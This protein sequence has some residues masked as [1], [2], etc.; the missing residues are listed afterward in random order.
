LSG[1]YDRA[2]H[3]LPFAGKQHNEKMELTINH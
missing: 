1:Q 3:A 2:H